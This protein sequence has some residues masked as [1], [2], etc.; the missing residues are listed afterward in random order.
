MCLYVWSVETNGLW[1]NRDPEQFA[2]IRLYRF[3]TQHVST[4]K[5]HL[6]QI[7][8]PSIQYLLRYDLEGHSYRILLIKVPIFLI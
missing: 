3:H 6:D 5:L 2:Q 1:N 8:Y 7:L 4:L